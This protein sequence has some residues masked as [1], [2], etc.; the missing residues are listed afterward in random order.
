MFQAAFMYFGYAVAQAVIQNEIIER[1]KSKHRNQEEDYIFYSSALSCYA[2]M[3]ACLRLS[4]RALEAFGNDT[5]LNKFREDYE[6]W[7]VKLIGAR[8]KLQAHPDELKSFVLKRS[9]ENDKGEITFPVRNLENITES[10]KITILPQ[11]DIVKLNNYLEG[12]SEHAI[13]IVNARDTTESESQN[14]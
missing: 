13:R 14:K 10:T 1:T 12:I 8:D 9:G 2:H 7:A 5:D 6:N 11:E 4:K 3:R